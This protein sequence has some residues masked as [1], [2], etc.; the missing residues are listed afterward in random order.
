MRTSDIGLDG[1]VGK[2]AESDSRPLPRLVGVIGAVDVLSDNVVRRTCCVKPLEGDAFATSL[3]RTLLLGLLGVCIPMPESSDMGPAWSEARRFGRVVDDRSIARIGL[4]AS[5]LERLGSVMIAR[6]C[7]VVG[8]L[9]VSHR[10][11]LQVY[12]Q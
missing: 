3:K 7:G 2:S 5:R 11:C 1:G 8:G 12:G 6:R 9:R 4:L 10:I